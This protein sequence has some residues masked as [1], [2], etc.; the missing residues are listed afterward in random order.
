MIVKG[1]KSAHLLGGSMTKQVGGTGWIFLAPGLAWLLCE[2]S[3]TRILPPRELGRI[4]ELF[5]PVQALAS[6]LTFGGPAIVLWWLPRI[7]PDAW[8]QAIRWIICW[9]LFISASGVTLAAM[10]WPGL[11]FLFSS[12]SYPSG[13]VLCCLLYL[14]LTLFAGLVES[15]LLATARV[16]RALISASLGFF[17]AL[18]V[19]ASLGYVGANTAAIALPCAFAASALMRLFCGAY[20]LKGIIAKPYPDEPREHLWP[21]G[22]FPFIVITVTLSL[23]DA[24][25]SWADRII[26][27]SAFSKT[28]EVLALYRLGA[29]EIPLFSAWIGALSAIVLVRLSA[30][31]QHGASVQANE[32]QRW[33]KTV[34]FLWLVV[35][36]FAGGLWV[37]APELFGII[38]GPSW[39]G[40]AEYFR[41]YLV[42]VIV[43]CVPLL[44]LLQA[45]GMFRAV[46]AG[47]LL[48]SVIS[49][50]GGALFV[51]CW[52]HGPGAAAWAFVLGTLAQA[53]FYMAILQIGG[54]GLPW[55]QLIVG[56][57]F[58]GFFVALFWGLTTVGSFPLS[59]GIHG[60]ALCAYTL[61]LFIW[62]RPSLTVEE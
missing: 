9:S 38:Y 61:A 33:S 49:I 56:L 28:P 50:G 18:I 1:G 47:S 58:S 43:R 40:A 17:T 36:P 51:L 37:Y 39:V 26:V 21:S 46:I 6:L 24:L 52:G 31:A 10:V 35:L 62:Y 11:G 41:I 22:F 5:L 8:P 48:D 42:L 2:W 12:N 57:S 29:R 7:L 34:G 54:I 15:L 59:A 45:R 4:Y 13:L 16:G 44:A 20:F 32:I 19:C 23:L 3:V 14:G 53:I 55:R 27:Q 30:S 25:S 60:L